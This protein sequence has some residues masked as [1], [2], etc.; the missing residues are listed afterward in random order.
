MNIEILMWFIFIIHTSSLVCEMEIKQL[1]NLKT[2]FTYMYA[3]V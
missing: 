1:Y 2:F 3:N